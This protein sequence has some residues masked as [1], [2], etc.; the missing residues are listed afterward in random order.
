MGGRNMVYKNTYN[1]KLQNIINKSIPRLLRYMPNRYPYLLP[2]L[3][4]DNIRYLG[5]NNDSM[6][7]NHFKKERKLIPV[8]GG[9]VNGS[10]S[11]NRNLSD[12]KFNKDI[13]ENSAGIHV[14][15]NNYTRKGYDKK[16][17]YKN[18]Y[19]FTGNFLEILSNPKWV[20]QC[21]KFGTSK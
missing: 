9:V 18:S 19:L 13:H 16:F 10:N 12:G 15:S 8:E 11:Y 3:R 20:Q 1:V 6:N 21:S 5:T 7:S 14:N 2:D 17:I 4:A